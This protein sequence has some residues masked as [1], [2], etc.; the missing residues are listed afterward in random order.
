MPEVNW[1]AFPLLYVFNPV[2]QAVQ[3]T[4][5][6]GGEVVLKDLHDLRRSWATHILGQGVLPSVVVSWGGWKDWE[7]F[8]RHYLG[9]FSPEVLERE[10]EKVDFLADG[11]PIE[12]ASATDTMLTGGRSYA[13]D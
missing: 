11:D 7:T 5:S 6:L 2:Q 10:R 9:E 8:R 3:P 12:A 13:D 1:H 4:F